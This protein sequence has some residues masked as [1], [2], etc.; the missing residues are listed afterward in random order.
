MTEDE[1]VREMNRAWNS[2]VGIAAIA[3]IWITYLTVE[4]CCQ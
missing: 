4:F 1:R 3:L 2:I